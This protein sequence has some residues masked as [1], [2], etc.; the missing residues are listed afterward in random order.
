MHD[1]KNRRTI[2]I[3][4]HIFGADM[5]P[6]MTSFIANIDHEIHYFL[7]IKSSDYWILIVSKYN[8]Q[9]FYFFRA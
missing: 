8:I 3:V 5:I 7:D 2:K 4:R 1:K 6:R 9:V